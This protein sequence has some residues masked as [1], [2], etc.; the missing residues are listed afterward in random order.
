MLTH[1][2]FHNNPNPDVGGETHFEHCNFAQ[3]QPLEF[4]G[5]YVG[6]P[7]FPDAQNPEAFIFRHCNLTNCE[8]PL[9]ALVQKCHTGIQERG[10]P[11]EHDVITIDGHEIRAHRKV[12]RVHGRWVNGEYEYL[13][14]PLEYDDGYLED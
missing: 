6:V 9:G 11:G 12:N 4:D 8:P 10:V 3:S 1:K 14:E 2:S 13:A 7:L 5:E